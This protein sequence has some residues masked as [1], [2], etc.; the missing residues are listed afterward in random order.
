MHYYKLTDTGKEVYKKIDLGSDEGKILDFLR[1]NKGGT[2]D[3]LAAVVSGGDYIVKKM[4][5]SGLVYELT[6][7]PGRV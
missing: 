3:Q 1:N 2:D 4:K 7:E 5:G 6:T